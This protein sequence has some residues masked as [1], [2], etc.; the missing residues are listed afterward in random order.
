MAN[1]SLLITKIGSLW[2]N[3]IVLFAIAFLT[4]LITASAFDESY[5]LLHIAVYV[6]LIG[7][8]IAL[9]IMPIIASFIKKRG[10]FMT[11]LVL[12]LFNAVGSMFLYF[13]HRKEMK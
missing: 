5:K 4:F 10:I 12:V 7:A 11:V 6:T 13:Y 1:T 8:F 9:L 3:S 2:R